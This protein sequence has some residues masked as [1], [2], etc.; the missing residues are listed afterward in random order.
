M[1]TGHT[2]RMRALGF[3]L[4]APHQ[5]IEANKRKIHPDAVFLSVTDYIRR[6]SKGPFM[7]VAYVFDAPYNIHRCPKIYNMDFI[8]EHSPAGN[9]I[10]S[11]KLKLGNLWRHTLSFISDEWATPT[12]PDTQMREIIDAMFSLDN[13]RFNTLYYNKV[14]YYVPRA[15]GLR[16]TFKQ[17]MCDILLGRTP[18]QA[19]LVWGSAVTWANP[20]KVLTEF[21]TIVEFLQSPEGQTYIACLMTCHRYLAACAPDVPLRNLSVEHDTKLKEIVTMHKATIY[22]CSYWIELDR[23]PVK[24][25]TGPV[26]GGG[27]RRRLQTAALEIDGVDLSADGDVDWDAPLDG[28]G[29]TFDGEEI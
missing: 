6:L 13:I 20:K 16:E 14:L 15:N 9:I 11:K 2:V 5:V 1:T 27:P 10:K 12:S 21:T 3:G 18:P 29:N 19:L 22:E 28:A 17:K 25:A 8:I 7:R 23:K 4:T 26:L 24:D